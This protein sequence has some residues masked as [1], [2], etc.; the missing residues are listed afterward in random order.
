VEA[1]TCDL[2]VVSARLDG[3]LVHFC[4]PRQ[5]AG[6]APRPLSAIDLSRAFSDVSLHDVVVE[7]GALIGAG[8]GRTV[9]TGRAIALAAVLASAETVG[10][11][12]HLFAMTLD[13]AKNRVAFGQPI[14]AFQAI[15][16]Q[17]ADLSLRLECCRACLAAAA[18]DLDRGVAWAAEA[19]SIVKAFVADS[20]T[21][22]AQGCLQIHGGIGFTW[23][24]DLHL[25]YRRLAAD[26]AVWGDAAWH[27]EHVCALQGI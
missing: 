24:H 11:M 3:D 10:A 12:A 25:Y 8:T 13:H 4:V 7:P 16:H 21:A 18:A 17:L 5:T 15:K 14:G 6:V 27:R 22:L 1:A 9:D 23:E 2:F 19:A 26:A 20:A